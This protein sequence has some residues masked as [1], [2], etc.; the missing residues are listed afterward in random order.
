[1]QSVSV[2]ELGE[3]AKPGDGQAFSARPEIV[4]ETVTTLV[5]SEIPMLPEAAAGP[6]GLRLLMVTVLPEIVAISA[7]LPD[8]TK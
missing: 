1:M 6:E 5:P 2:T 3:A 4:T 8:A 7:S